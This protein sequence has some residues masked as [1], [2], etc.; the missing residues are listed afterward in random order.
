MTANGLSAAIAA[1]LGS[2]TDPAKQT[3]FCDKLASAIVTYI[4]ANAKC[5]LPASSVVT[6]GSAATQTGP[7]APVV[8]AVT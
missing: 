2:A 1:A 8:M 6:V 3:D 7:A 5:T 4:Q